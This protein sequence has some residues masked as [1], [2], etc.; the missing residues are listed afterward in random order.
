M[1]GGWGLPILPCSD[2]FVWDRWSWEEE[3]EEKGEIAS[4]G[5]DEE[6]N[7][8]E[9][10]EEEEEEETGSRSSGMQTENVSNKLILSLVFIVFCLPCQ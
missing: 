10:E 5:E 2:I 6:E 3:E 4:H 9:K 7:D 1:C 8:E